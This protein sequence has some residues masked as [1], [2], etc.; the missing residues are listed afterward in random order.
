MIPVLR[1]ISYHRTNPIFSQFTPSFPYSR[2]QKDRDDLER[3]NSKEKSKLAASKE[4][5]KAF[6]ALRLKKGKPLD[7]WT[8]CSVPNLH[9]KKVAT[10]TKRRKA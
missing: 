4:R 9:F 10:L 6:H 5:L 3:E 2:L 1:V 8:V 7:T